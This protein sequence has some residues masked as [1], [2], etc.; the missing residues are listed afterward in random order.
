MDDDQLLTAG[1][2]PWMGVPLWVAVPG[3]EAHA[4]V[5]ITKARAEGLSFRPLQHT[6]R[7]TLAWDTAR[8]GPPPE[9]VGLTPERE[10]ELLSL[11]ADTTP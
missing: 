4:Q 1:V 2:N 10:D 7:D 8:G 11:R 9:V 6:I 3:W 5:D